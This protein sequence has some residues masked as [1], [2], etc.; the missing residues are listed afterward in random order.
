[1][2]VYQTSLHYFLIYL[3]NNNLNIIVRFSDWA[4]FSVWF[5]PFH[6][7]A[8]VIL[9]CAKCY[10]Y[11]LL[12]SL[13]LFLYLIWIK[14]LIVWDSSELKRSF[15]YP[16][17]I[18]IQNK[19]LPSDSIYD[20]ICREIF[21]KSYYINPKSYCIHHFPIDMDPIGQCPFGSKLIEKW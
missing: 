14:Q 20:P 7:L 9:E 10:C 16:Y 18:L 11:G 6:S 5:F 13:I 15:W 21:S 17:M 12:V 4:T 3:F 2:H 8:S 1:M 19:N